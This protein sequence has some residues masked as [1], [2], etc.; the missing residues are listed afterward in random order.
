MS[1]ERRMDI[2]RAS[3][4][5]NADLLLRAQHAIEE[6]TANSLR[7]Q[8]VSSRGRIAMTGL[9]DSLERLRA[10][11]EVLGLNIPPFTGP[12]GSGAAAPRAASNPSPASRPLE[13]PEI[14]VLDL[15][16][17]IVM[18]NESWRCRL[19]SDG[20]DIR[21]GG[22][23]Q[24]YLSFE[25]LRPVLGDLPAY[26]SG[27][28]AVLGGVKHDLDLTVRIGRGVDRRRFRLNAVRLRG[29]TADRVVIRREDVTDL[30]E[31]RMDLASL[32]G[33]LVDAQERERARYAEELHDSTAQHLTAAALNLMALKATEGIGVKAA[34]IIA[35][36][37]RSLGEA[38]GEIRSISYL[39]H[40]RNLDRD[41]LRATMRRFVS[42]FAER[43][44]L[45]VR[46]EISGAVDALSPAVQRA[47]LRIV[48]EAFTNVHRHA[49]ASTVA[50]SAT[51][52]DSNLKLAIVDDGCGFGDG[53]AGAGVG[54][55]G[56]EARANR[57]GGDLHIRSNGSGTRILVRIPCR[58]RSKDRRRC[59]AGSRPGPQ[60]ARRGF[61]VSSCFSRERP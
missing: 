33:R 31:S 40:P 59:D 60:G 5:G 12:F 29:A 51:V 27:L 23:G 14:V 7:T 17:R 48:Q 53:G 49:A 54:I 24:V 30:H 25:F 55:A 21:D 61:R 4:A 15:E 11:V 50:L 42:G 16:G 56:M 10:D 28:A 9:R 46:A 37:E 38:L 26:R 45:E 20:P 44:K 58:R 57:F 19:R 1:D 52:E 43:T 2:G 18:G 41:G 34:G 32:T 22:I 47:A 35:E 39:L 36:A 6:N 3:S 13:D 8:I